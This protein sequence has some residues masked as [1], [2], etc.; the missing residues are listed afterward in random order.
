MEKLASITRSEWRAFDA[1]LAPLK[2]ASFPINDDVL[3]KGATA[4]FTVPHVIIV[5]KRR[6]RVN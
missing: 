1:I 3:W 4:F 2:I 5:E 6:H